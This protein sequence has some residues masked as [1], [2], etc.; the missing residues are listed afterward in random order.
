MHT[1][2][3]VD[4]REIYMHLHMTT[5]EL[6]ARQGVAMAL[7][8]PKVAPLVDASLI[9]Q[10]SNTVGVEESLEKIQERERQ[11]KEDVK[12]GA[13]KQLLLMA[14]SGEEERRE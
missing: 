10:T 6:D 4:S 1:A 13:A 8:G 3:S 12:E 11:R 2:I 9:P 7:Y 5:M 14:S